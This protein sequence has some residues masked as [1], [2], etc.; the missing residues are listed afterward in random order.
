M[1]GNTRFNAEMEITTLMKRLDDTR[2]SSFGPWPVS[3]FMIS[4]TTRA[5][6]LEKALLNC[7][8]AHKTGRYEPMVAAI[9]AAENLLAD[10]TE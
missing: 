8:K 2:K 4:Q 5:G 9:E 10:Q 3:A 7:I 6:E 1:G